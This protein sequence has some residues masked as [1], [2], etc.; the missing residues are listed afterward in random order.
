MAVANFRLIV[1]FWSSFAA[2]IILIAFAIWYFVRGTVIEGVV[3]ISFIA[4]T[5][6]IA[7]TTA[8][9]RRSSP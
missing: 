5:A 9:R 4:V 8:R 7:A 2:T 1:R 6:G 3:I